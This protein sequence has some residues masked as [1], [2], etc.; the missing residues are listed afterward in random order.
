MHMLIKCCL[1]FAIVEHPGFIEYHRK[2]DPSFK[3]PCRKTLSSK[4]LEDQRNEVIQ[5]LKTMFADESFTI[6]TSVD[7]WAD[8]TKRCFNG[9]IAQFIDH[10]W[11]LKTIPFAFEYVTGLY[12]FLKSDKHIV[13]RI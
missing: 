7:G 11:K 10:V 13:L 8:E 4:K 1:P 6:N 5:K 9:Y 3:V 2:L 12:S